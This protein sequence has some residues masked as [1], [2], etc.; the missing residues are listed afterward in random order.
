MAGFG[1]PKPDGNTI[2]EIGSVTKTFTAVLLADALQRGD[3]TLDEPVQQLLP[4]FSIP[5][6]GAREKPRAKRRSSRA[7]RSPSIQPRCLTT[8]ADTR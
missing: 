6:S 2:F 7:N 8:S 1:D 5:K 4:G 3:V